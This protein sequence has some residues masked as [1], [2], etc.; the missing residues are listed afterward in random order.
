MQIALP[1]ANIFIDESK[2]IVTTQE[3]EVIEFSL[4]P[5]NH[6]IIVSRDGYFPWKK[7]FVMQ[8]EG[9]I[10][11]SPVF[12]SSSPSGVI[13]TNKD[14]EFWKIRNKIITDP[15]PTKNAPRTSGDGKVKLWIEDNGV[16]IEIASTTK[17]VIQPD[18]AIKNLYFY[19]DR[20]DIVIF[21]IANAIYVIETSKEGTQNFMPIYKGN[22]PS[23]IEGDLNYIYV[24]DNGTLMQVTI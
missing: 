2:K 18:P 11:F 7:D 1:A 4:S 23:F 6:T 17:T 10:N 16:M 12:V 15:L 24:L 14:P 13:I 9:N 21:S 3:N 5:R 22:D 20:S 19:K 8:S